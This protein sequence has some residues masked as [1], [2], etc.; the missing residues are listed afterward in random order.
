MI[1]DILYR[2]VQLLSVP[3]IQFKPSEIPS[4]LSSVSTLSICQIAKILGKFNLSIYRIVRNQFVLVNHGVIH[5]SVISASD[6]KLNKAFVH[7]LELRLIHAFHFVRN[8][9]AKSQVAVYRQII[10]GSHQRRTHNRVC[11]ALF[12]FVTLTNHIDDRCHE[13]RCFLSKNFIK[14]I[15]YVIS[16]KDPFQLFHY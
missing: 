1:F 14:P 9:C 16:C 11:V 13:L 5:S 4:N 7:N 10:T 12:Q 2:H 8:Q 6:C 3:C 15:L